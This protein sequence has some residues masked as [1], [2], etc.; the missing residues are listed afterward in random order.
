MLTEERLNGIKER[1]SKAQAIK[2]AFEGTVFV[3][4]AR[5]D[6]PDLLAEIERLQTKEKE[7]DKLYE[8]A[9]K[10]VDELTDG[11]LSKPYEQAV[12]VDVV[13]TVYRGDYMAKLDKSYDCITALM[14]LVKVQYELMDA[15]SREIDAANA[16]DDYTKGGTIATRTRLDDARQTVL[17]V[18]DKGA[19]I[20]AKCHEL[21]LEV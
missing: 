6:V 3:D 16:E 7:C 20:V 18:C 2:Y 1:W 15:R 8:W 10:L 5:K 9:C 21:G 4:Y 13:D 19:E 14:D 12:I 11:K 17:Q